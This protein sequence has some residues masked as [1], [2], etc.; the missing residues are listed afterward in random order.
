MTSSWSFF[1]QR[2]AQLKTERFANPN[3]P[4]RSNLGVW[5]NDFTQQNAQ[6]K[7]DLICDLVQ[8]DMNSSTV[9]YAGRGRHVLSKSASSSGRTL[10][11]F[12]L[13][14]LSL[15]IAQ[16]HTQ[17]QTHTHTHTYRHTRRHTDTVR[18]RERERPY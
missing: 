11:R 4:L 1:A 12:K 15:S 10:K 14:K 7:A 9:R 8:C 3:Y 13:Y 6:R 17:T 5:I 18:E 16:T 2:I